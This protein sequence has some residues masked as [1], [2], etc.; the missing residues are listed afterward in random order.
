M[1]EAQIEV[2]LVMASADSM[3]AII[4]RGLVDVGEC[5][6]GR[7]CSRMEFMKCRSEALF[8]LGITRASRLGALRTVSRLGVLVWVQGIALGFEMR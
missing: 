1:E 4:F 7:V 5:R 6:A 2:R 3:S 8:T